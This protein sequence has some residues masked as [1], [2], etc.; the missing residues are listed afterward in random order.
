MNPTSADAARLSLLLVQLLSVSLRGRVAAPRISC[1]LDMC[2]PR[3]PVCDIT[4]P[5]AHHPLLGI[6]VTPLPSSPSTNSASCLPRKRRW[7]SISTPS[8]GLEKLALGL[9]GHRRQSSLFPLTHPTTSIQIPQQRFAA[10][11]H[12]RSPVSEGKTPTIQLLA[13]SHVGSNGWLAATYL[14]NDALLDG[15]HA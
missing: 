7:C 2:P 11:A 10:Q 15:P 8:S 12:I 13:Q 14:S 9:P 3:H 6:Q 5:L 4:L 1:Y